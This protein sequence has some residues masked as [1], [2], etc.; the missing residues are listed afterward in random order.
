[1]RMLIQFFNWGL[2][3]STGGTDHDIRFRIGLASASIRKFAKE[4]NSSAAA[5]TGKELSYGCL[6]PM[7][8]AD[9]R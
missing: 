6:T 3:G 5:A 2:P 1:M 4:W 8:C 9:I 7:Y